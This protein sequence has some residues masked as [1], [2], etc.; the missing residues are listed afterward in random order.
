MGTQ[1]PAHPDFLTVICDRGLGIR[2]IEDLG[3]ED[4][5]IED[6]GIEDLGIE[7]LEIVRRSCC[8][9]RSLTALL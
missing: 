5:G 9:G 2:G 6:L 1:V 8:C 7:D 4:L 3:I